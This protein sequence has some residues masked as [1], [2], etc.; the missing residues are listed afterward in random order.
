MNNNSNNFQN[1]TLNTQITSPSN[2]SSTFNEP[3]RMST[4]SSPSLFAANGHFYE[5]I[6]AGSISTWEEAR[7]AAATRTYEG[8]QGYLATVT[9]AEEQAFVQ[10]LLN[11]NNAWLGGTDVATEGQ[12]NWVTG[13]EADATFWNNGTV[14]GQFN[15]WNSG[16]EPNGGTNEN[17]VAMIGNSNLS[18]LLGRWHD[19]SQNLG[20]GDYGTTG[21]IVEYGGL[22]GDVIPTTSRSNEFFWRNYPTGENA[23]WEISS[24]NNEQGQLEVN[25]ENNNPFTSIAGRDWLMEAV[26]DFNGDGQ[27]DVFFHNNVTGETQVWLMQKDST[28]GAVT[29]SGTAN[30]IYTI[31][32]AGWQVAGVADFDNNGVSDIV[33][34]NQITGSNGVWMMQSSGGTVSLGSAHF[35]ASDAGTEWSIEHVADVNDN[36]QYDLIWRNNT[37]GENAIWE[38]TYTSTDA[39]TDTP[40]PTTTTSTTAAN[41][42][43]NP[44]SRTAAYAV[45]P[46]ESPNSILAAVADFNGDNILDF[47][48]HND[49]TGATNIWE[50]SAGTSGQVSRNRENNLVNTG[51]NAGWELAGV[52]QLNQDATPDFVWRNYRT[53]DNFAWSINYDATNGLTF[54]D[55]AV[56]YGTIDTNWVLESVEP[57][58]SLV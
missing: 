40:V 18:S 3:I 37:T 35:I 31:G 48:W 17:Y 14:S 10:G 11:G 30:S 12:W 6:A 24:S 49:V 2:G 29:R 16:V 20:S 23:Y 54:G 8:R 46:D 57:V 27:N 22:P 56:V 38:M 34:R 50:M 52:A 39:A 47:V 5:F 43:N 53:G 19:S 58:T 1:A 51:A 4:S 45:T 13:P 36:G 25:L 26:A 9:S 32:E 15:N 42:A 28:T 55:D 41:A 7:D 44:F 21:Y 33:W